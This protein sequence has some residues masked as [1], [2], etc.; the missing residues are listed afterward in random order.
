MLKGKRANVHPFTLEAPLMR[1]SVASLHRVVKRDLPIKFV[2]QE[3]M[4]NSALRVRRDPRLQLCHRRA[5]GI[6]VD[7]S[8]RSC[9]IASV[10]SAFK[11][12]RSVVT[13]TQ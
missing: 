10:F 4:T 11:R 12:S 3:L 5:E 8:L 6:Q 13:T 7:R 1:L 2:P 9:T